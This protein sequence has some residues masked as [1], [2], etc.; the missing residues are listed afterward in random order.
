MLEPSQKKKGVKCD[1]K[2]LK[3]VDDQCD[4]NG[5]C[6]GIDKCANV[7]CQAK[8]TCYTKGVCNKFTG[9]CSNP[10]KKAGASCDDKDYKTVLDVCDAKGVCKGINKCAKVK[11]TKKSQCHKVGVCNFKT[12]QCSNPVHVG[13]KCDDKKAKTTGDKCDANAVCRGVD[14]LGVDEN[15]SNAVCNFYM[16]NHGVKGR[17]H[18][19]AW[20][21]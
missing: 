15:V 10:R 21:G 2:N 17:A 3:T 6:K 5:V 1:D 16:F 4:G 12:G 14:K 9:K 20:Y 7:G 18:L 11:C 13:A 8:N 19:T